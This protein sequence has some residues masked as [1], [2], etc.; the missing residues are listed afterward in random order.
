MIQKL[1]REVTVRVEQRNAIATVEVL[2]YHIT[3]QGSLTRT[4]LTNDVR[5]PARVSDSDSKREFGTVRTFV[6]EM[7]V[8]LAHGGGA[9]RDS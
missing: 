8:V 1:I 9:S 5:V 3:Q 2:Q 4:R 7:N 6:S